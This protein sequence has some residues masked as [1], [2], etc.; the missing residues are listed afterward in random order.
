MSRGNT[1]I[2]WK[3]AELLA[4]AG[5]GLDVPNDDGEARKLADEL[6]NRGLAKFNLA[7]QAPVNGQTFQGVGITKLGRQ[8]LRAYYLRNMGGVRVWS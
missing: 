2:G 8:A 7:R 3:E 1:D 5:C 6:K 4:L